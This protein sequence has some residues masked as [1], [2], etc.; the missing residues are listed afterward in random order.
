MTR[1]RFAVAA[2]LAAVCASADAA[3]A[4]ATQ[5]PPLTPILAGKKLVTPV[6][7][8]ADV[9]FTQPVTRRE[10]GLVVTR[11]QL[12][13]ISSA[14]IARLT[15]DETWYD[16]AGGLVTG[17]KGVVNGLLQPGEVQIV[18]IETPFNAKMKANNYNFTHANGV[19]KPHRVDKMDAPDAKDG[20]PA[21]KAA[22]KPAAK[23]K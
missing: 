21:A 6:R 16:A 3:W 15:I 11:I 20:K 23:P 19:V 7:G 1:A 8:V 5:A 10:K 18:R 4:Q 22:A 12:K 14:P 2:T 9:E 17:S 13:N